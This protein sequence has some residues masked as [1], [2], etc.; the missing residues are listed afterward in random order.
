MISFICKIQKHFSWVLAKLFCFILDILIFDK[1][2]DCYFNSFP[3]IF[4]NY[5]FFFIENAWKILH[6]PITKFTNPIIY[7]ILI[8]LNIILLLQ[9][10]QTFIHLI[11]QIFLIF[12]AQN[13]RLKVRKRIKIFILSFKDFFN[14]FWFLLQALD[15]LKIVNSDIESIISSLKRATYLNNIPFF[16]FKIFKKRILNSILSFSPEYAFNGTC[17]IIN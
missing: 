5:N 16:K 4:Q 8:I 14:Q 6:Y 17:R 1:L 10:I 9:T 2:Y 7:I 3:T 13:F 15:N 11:S 12:W